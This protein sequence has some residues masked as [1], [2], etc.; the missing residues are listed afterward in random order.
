MLKSTHFPDHAF[1]SSDAVVLMHQGKVLAQGSPD[2]A[3]TRD[4]LHLLYGVEVNILTQEG[5]IRCC[6]P[7]GAGK[8]PEAS[9]H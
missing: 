5:G 3:M 9:V 1:L 8:R 7:A 2:E 4:R 6:V